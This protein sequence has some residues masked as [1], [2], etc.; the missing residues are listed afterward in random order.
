MS[1]V[2]VCGVV[3]VNVSSSN[4]VRDLFYSTARGVGNIRHFWSVWPLD[5]GAASPGDFYQK[6]N[7]RVSTDEVLHI[8]R[9]E[10]IAT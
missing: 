1:G 8:L 3:V 5:H 10:G 7:M 6:P 4:Q 9:I 2:S